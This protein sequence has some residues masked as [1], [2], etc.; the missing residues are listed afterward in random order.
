MKINTYSEI[1]RAISI[2]PTQLHYD[3][4]RLQPSSIKPNKCQP[5]F[6]NVMRDL[7]QSLQVIL[8]GIDNN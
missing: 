2:F 8:Q 6:V 7:G 4:K 3:A 1:T 5:F